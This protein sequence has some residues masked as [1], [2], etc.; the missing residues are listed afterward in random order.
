MDNARQGISGDIYKC[1]P[2]ALI[3]M[4]ITPDL[5][6]KLTLLIE[7]STNFCCMNLLKS[8]Y[9]KVAHKQNKTEK[10][11]EKTETRQP[12]KGSKTY[13]KRSQIEKGEK[14]SEREKESE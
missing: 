8:L 11:W 5:I 4:P 7:K 3:D 12:K 13:K 6:Q 2:A 10:N 14:K 9:D 1:P